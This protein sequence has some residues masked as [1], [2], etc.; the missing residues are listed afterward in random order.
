MS[1]AVFP[2]EMEE[3]LAATGANGSGSRPGNMYDYG[4]KSGVVAYTNLPTTGIGSNTIVNLAGSSASAGVVGGVA[5]LVRARYLYMNNQAVMDRL[6]ST[7]GGECAGLNGA[8]WRDA[9]VNAYAALGGICIT[10]GVSQVVNNTS[11]QTGC[12][13]VPPQ[14]ICSPGG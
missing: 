2:A 3:V 9:V 14:I 12:S 5:A 7:S 13:P 8:A 1:T 6:I 11:T 4:T 10:R